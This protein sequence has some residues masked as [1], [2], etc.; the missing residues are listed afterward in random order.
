MIQ[1]FLGGLDIL[2]GA[3]VKL[4]LNEVSGQFPK[5]NHPP[6]TLFGDGGN[7]YR[8]PFAVFHKVQLAADLRVAEIPDFRI[9][10]FHPF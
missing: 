9:G 8:N 3:T 6:D 4:Q 5:A 2:I 1:F 10:G 7:L